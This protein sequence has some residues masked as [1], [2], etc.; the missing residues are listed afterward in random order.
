MGK[1]A[2]S[3]LSTVIT[4][5]LAAVAIALG[6]IAA[7]SPALADSA[8]VDPT[9]PSTP[10]TVT[11]D[12]LPTPQIDGV[13]WSQKVVGNVV[14]AGG[15]WSTIRPYGSAKGV[16]QISQPDLLAYN[17][18]TG[19]LITTF[20]PQLNGQVKAVA[21]SPDNSVLYV[22]GQFTTVNGAT[23]TRIAAL[24]PATGALIKTFSAA[25]NATVN[26]LATYGST[27]YLGGNFSG[28]GNSTRSYA[29]AVNASTGALLPWAPNIAG[30]GVAA[31]AV[32]PDG[33]KVV[34]GG[35][36]TSVAGSTNPGYGLA[37]VDPT[38]A[39]LLPWNADN[40]VQDGG[41]NAGITSLTADSTG[42]YGSGFVFGAGGNVEGSFRADWAQGNLTWLESCHGDTY[43]TAVT[44]DAEYVAGHPHYCGDIGGFQQA[45]NSANWV[46]H[47]GLA[48]SLAATQKTTADP[49]TPAYADFTGTPAPSILTWFPDFNTGTFTGQSQGPWSVAASSDS[50]YVVY[51]GEFTTVNGVAQQG[52][53]RFAVSSLSTNKQGPMVTGANFVPSVVSLSS[54][55]ARVSFQSNWDR[56]NSNLTYNVYRNGGATPVYTT[57]AQSTFWQ[58]PTLGFV[59]K[60]LTPG[61]Q[62]SYRVSATDSFGNTVKG[63]S[64]YVTITSASPSN[65]VDTVSS[66]GASS[67]WR[68]NEASG[69]AVYD[70]V[71]YNDMTTTGTVT[72]GASGSAS[73]GSKATT[74]DG[75]TGYAAT[76]TA[77]AGPQT[78]SVE[79]WINTTSTAG[80]VIAGFGDQNTTTS[81]N[82]DRHLY[83]DTNG[84]VNFGVYDG[85]TEILTSPKPLNDG[86]WHQVIGT[87]S[88]AG[89]TFYVDGKLVGTNA[90]ITSAQV[91]NGYWRI[92]GDSTWSGAQFFSGNI[93]DVSVYPTA[94]SRSQ[95]DAQWVAAGNTSTIPAAPK[96]AYGSQVFTDSPSLYYRLDD[97][98][99]S[100][101]A[102]DSSPSAIDG[103]YSGGVTQGAA[104]ALSGTSDTAATFDGSSGQVASSQSFNDPET[105]T[106][107]AW[108]KTTTTTGGKIIGFGSSQTGL[109]SS[110]DR[111]IYMQDNG[112]LV[113]GTYTGQE[114]TITTPGSYND[115]AWHYVTASQSSAGLALY[116]DGQL[117]GT[118]PTTQAQ[119]YTGY[120]KIG[121]D[122]TWGSSSPYFAGTIDEAAVYPQA[123]SASTIAQHYALG[124]GTTATVTPTSSFT[125]TPTFLKVAFD[126]TGSSEKGGSIASYAWDFG[127]G[128][129]STSS[130]PSHTYAS[131]GTYTVKLTVTDA[132]GV[133]GTSSQQVVVTAPTPPTASFTST[134]T[135][136]S[137]AFDASGSSDTSG[138]ITSYAWDYGDGTTG[139]GVT[140]THAYTAAGTYTVK[141]TLTDSNGSTASSSAQVSVTKALVPPTASF[142]ATQTNLAAAF[143]ATGSSDTN[144]TITGYAWDFGDGTTG[145]GATPGHTY[146]AAGTYTV[147]LTVTDSN[148]LTGTASQSVT[149]AAASVPPTAAFTSTSSGLTLTADGTSSTA[150]SAAITGYAWTF[151]D[152][153]TS[154]SSKPSHTYASAATY[155]VTLTVTDA[156]GKTGTSSQSVT[157][158]KANVPPTASFTETTTGLTLA[159]DATGS[160]DPD[161]TVA[162]YAWTFGDGT[163]ATG[164]TPSHTFASAGTYAVKL[165][166]TDNQGAT[167][168]STQS[169]TVAAPTPPTSSFT[170]STSGLTVSTDAS[171]SAATGGTISSYAWTFGDGGTA[172][173]KTASHAYTAAGTY[174]V[175]LKVTDSNALTNTSTQSVTVSQPVIQ[176]F[177]LDT[178]NRSVTGGWGS[179]NT[180][181]AWTKAG[182]ASNLT[183]SNNAGNLLLPTTGTQIAA[184]L[185]GPSQTSSN[186]LYSFTL[187]KAPTGGGTYV[188]AIPRGI[189]TNNEYRAQVRLL[190]TGVVG[191]SLL[192]YNGSSTATTLVSEKTISGL[193]AAAGTNYSVRVEAVGTSPTTIRARVWVTG[194]T[195]PTTWQVTTTDST[196]ALQAAGGVGVLGY[197]SGSATNAPQTVSISQLSATTTP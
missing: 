117:I 52:L 184:Y 114:N 100:T 188:S 33:S 134:P 118:N 66:Q 8:P 85:N 99:G 87:L 6:G 123:L 41:V 113:F 98:A 190:P 86:K 60:G 24:N 51:G 73:D 137:A 120:W 91:Y 129:T 7:A 104:G 16:N 84:D 142:T 59:D 196:P 148:K 164:A 11:A 145:T 19:A 68:L 186:L 69:T 105:Y 44:N 172:T 22:A 143:D 138:T 151:G 15:N 94:L 4:A 25:P 54:G 28:V 160:S 103:V 177:A 166:V 20:N 57:T 23:A 153:G 5:S 193:T 42:L 167:G 110:Y 53:T 36:F 67:L 171:G 168:S 34:V 112:Q 170:T 40:V 35:Q 38:S 101:T 115:G 174:T 9:S 61:V 179:A 45:A 65:Y 74:F 169:L 13:V 49:Y 21:M 192:A 50:K 140:S 119:A 130:I 161:G 55:T 194:T 3:R 1:F 37:A 88:P 48:F 109:S 81:S 10:T 106:E 47:R 125:A 121:G 144:G 136:L 132:N 146:V 139:T 26:A 89:E 82:Y 182:S 17:L 46:F 131:A 80:G 183:V 116:V 189:S 162:S 77:V 124:T 12:A 135:N 56:D 108:F 156:N 39:A 27:V 64:A 175:T 78:F 197:L 180:G 173:G 176:P 155:T 14:Y 111:H 76:K 133:T 107:E 187:A 75:S 30:G 43:S 79:A 83:M 178:F 62:Y 185:Y 149:V 70:N 191:L 58:L 63:D 150:G 31:V 165:T 163:T 96:D 32:D 122:Q 195:E 157:V 126:G 159:F 147:K 93:D 102:H 128:A 18:T 181:G 95:V 154:T 2:P 90:N 127:D 92:G 29:A 71:G 152:G 158:S 141:L 97:A 72:R